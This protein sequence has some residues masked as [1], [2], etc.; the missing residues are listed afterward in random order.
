[1]R[2]NV[3]AGKRPKEARDKGFSYTDRYLLYARV[4]VKAYNLEKKRIK[5]FSS[6]IPGSDWGVEVF[7]CEAL[8]YFMY[9]CLY[10]GNVH[11]Q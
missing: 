4:N 9:M 6:F 8:H 10:G 2:L 1:M 11:A 5:F 7:F 3:L